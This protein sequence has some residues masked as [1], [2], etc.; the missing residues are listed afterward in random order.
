MNDN[1]PHVVRNESLTVSSR[2]RCESE[3]GVYTVCS[4]SATLVATYAFG[5]GHQEHAEL[6]ERM[7][8]AQRREGNTVATSKSS[9]P[10]DAMS[11]VGAAN[12]AGMLTVGAP[13][14]ERRPPA[15]IAFAAGIIIPPASVGGP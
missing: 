8:G 1:A 4:G 10:G 12:E 7:C 13:F 15:S 5:R 14:A 6:T 11:A 2:P 9:A 3:P